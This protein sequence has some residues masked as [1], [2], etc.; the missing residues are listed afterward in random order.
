M[1]FMIVYLENSGKN[2]KKQNYLT[3]VVRVCFYEL[4]IVTQTQVT[5]NLSIYPIT[6][7][8]YFKVNIVTILA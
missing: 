4:Y 5:I 7:L 8:V 2:F 6:F 3:L 1:L